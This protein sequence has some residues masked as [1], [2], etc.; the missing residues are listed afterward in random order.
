MIIDPLLEADTLADLR[1]ALA[2]L[3]AHCW[4][5][6]T[7]HYLAYDRRR[8]VLLHRDEVLELGQEHQPGACAL[9]LRM[10]DDQSL[11]WPESLS[12]RGDYRMALPIFNWGSL[13]AVVC[14]SF[15]AKPPSL[16]GLAVVEKAL[17]SIGEKVRNQ[18]RIS[19]FVDRSKELWVQAI[20]AQGKKGH[21]ERILR[22]SSALAEML[23]LSAQVQAELVQAAQ[24]H[25]IGQLTFADPTT[26]QARKDHPLIG[27]GLLHHHPE[28][29]GVALLV[30]THHERFDGSGL[31]K[32]LSGNEV[33]MEGWVLALSED[34]VEQWE[35]SL[36][37]FET[38]VRNF[39]EGP[40]KHHHPDVVD[41]LC[42]LVDAG[43]LQEIL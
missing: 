2:A 33:P 23:D 6:R 8:Q 10:I 3:T 21:V 4:N 28:L 14:L 26:A 38:K 1:K 31:P 24:Y 11:E 13:S 29:S 32:G 12:V 25:D 30:E 20:E 42:G 15:E 16:E 43:K 40:A 36:E 34:V 5:A 39:F 22:L 27:A 9:S 17:G 18:D 35:G 41:A 37:K 7:T 19:Q